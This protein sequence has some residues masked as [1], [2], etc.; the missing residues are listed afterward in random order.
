[1]TSKTFQFDFSH[2]KNRPNMGTKIPNKGLEPYNPDKH[3][4]P[5]QIHHRVA[6][7][8]DCGSYIGKG[9]YDIICDLDDAISKIYPMYIVDQVK[10]KFGTLR[11][12]LN[13]ADDIIHGMIWMATEVSGRTCEDCGSMNDVIQTEGWVTTICKSCLEKRGE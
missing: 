4:Y 11:F 13:A 6:L 10:E 5:E 8:M 9:W 1:M 3:K 12:Y 2:L 7:G